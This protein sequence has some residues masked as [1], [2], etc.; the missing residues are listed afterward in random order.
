MLNFE[1]SYFLCNGS[2]S[3]THC[4]KCYYSCNH[5]TLL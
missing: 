2:S 5:F 3:S 1:G 4:R